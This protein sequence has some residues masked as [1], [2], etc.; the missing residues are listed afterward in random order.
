MSIKR[1]NQKQERKNRRKKRIRRSISGTA[2]RP[3]MSVFKSNK[4]I[5]VQV[6]DDKSGNTIASISTLEEGTKNLNNRTGDAFKLGEELGK[7]LKEQKIES[8]VFDRNGRLYHGVIKSLA[9]GTR[10]A[11]I[12]F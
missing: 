5:Y 1:L 11:G 8:V 3:R 10:K 9:D 7:R 6:I 12:K 2:E 4:N